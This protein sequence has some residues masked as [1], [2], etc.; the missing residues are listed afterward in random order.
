VSV[1]GSP[2]LNSAGEVV[3]LSAIVR[4]I[5]ERREADQARGLLASIVESSDDAIQGVTLDGT[6]VSWNRGAE[7]LYGYASQEIIGKNAAILAPPGRE[8]ELRQGLETILKGRKVDSFE[9]VRQRKD[10]RPVDVMLSVSPI[11]NP[12]GEV[13]GAAAI[14]H[15]IGKRLRAAR[16]L[17]ASEELFR[18]VF[19]NAPVGV[20][21]TGLNGRYLQVN[22]A[23]CRMLGYSEQE[24]LAT[25]WMELTHPDDLGPALRREEQVRAGSDGCGDAE[26]RHIHRDGHAVWGRV[27][28]SLVRDFGGSPLYVVVH[29]EDI[30]ERRQS[31]Q[32]LRSSEEKF[33]QLA[34]NMREVVWM[35]PQTANEMPYASPAYERVWGRTCDSARQNP[36]SWLEAVHPDD[37]E[38]A[39]LLFAAQTKG[40][41]VESEFRIRTPGG[42]EKWI[43]GR[44][45]PVHDQAGQLIRVAG[46]AEDITGRKR[47]EEE[48][49]YARE[50]ADAANRAKSRFLANMSHEIRTPMNGVMGMVELLLETGLTGEQRQYA[51]LAIESGRTLLALIDDILDFSRIEARKSVMQKRSFNLHQAVEDAVRLLRV[52]ASAKGLRFH[53]RVSPEIPPLLT[54]DARRLRQ[55]LTNLAAN[56]VKFTERGEVRLE[57]ALVSQANGEATV[58]FTVTDTG[59]GIRPD[60]ATALFSRFTQA[61]TSTT[62]KYGGAGIGLAI[63]KQLVEMMGG[64]I[65]VDSQEG[66]GS[67]FCFTAVF[68]AGANFPGSCTLR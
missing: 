33:R 5:S 59:I 54:G 66:Q 36:M 68:G 57:A 35:A 49:I 23:F 31:E 61:D 65:G 29:F 25:T 43:R 26:M 7:V 20:C 12:A 56:A 21:V 24:L 46:I 4:D 38:Q 53:S 60:Q 47:Y 39:R 52:Q 27:R 51:T 22:P 28:V 16:K 41:P 55:V 44:A 48:L 11:R 6:I 1:T 67:T 37:L 14:A 62:R 34:E 42:Q 64:T 32:A 30:T 19:A 45:F 58:R 15:D 9:T 13:V 50:G 3:A 18:G 10:G 2:I 40:E 8:H 63:S 17:R